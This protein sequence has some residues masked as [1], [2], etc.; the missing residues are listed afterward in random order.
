MKPEML[1]QDAILQTC[2]RDQ[3]A[4]GAVYAP[5][6]VCASMGIGQADSKGSTKKKKKKQKQKKKKHVKH[7][8]HSHT[9]THAQ[10]Y[11]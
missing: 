9:H 7:Y 11:T 5:V 6:N 8:F 2:N 1:G 3:C 10:T 4:V